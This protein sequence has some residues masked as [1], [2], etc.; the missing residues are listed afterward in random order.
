MQVAMIDSETILTYWFGADPDKAT[1]AKD[2]ADL[3][4]SK[5]TEVDREIRKRFKSSLQ[6]ASEGKLDHWLAEPRGRLAL[7]IVTDSFLAIF[8]AIHR[9]RSPWTRKHW[10]GVSRVSNRVMIDCCSPSSGYSFVSLWSIRNGWSTK[11]ER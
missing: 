1:L 8:T 5:N 6:L 7:I 3:W 11:N 4:W 2:R 10:S 9:R